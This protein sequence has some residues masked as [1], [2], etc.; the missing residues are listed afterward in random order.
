MLLNVRPGG[1]T[2][3]LPD[4]R[5]RDAELACQRRLR[6]A[7]GR[8]ASD[9]PDAVV[10]KFG[11]A[12]SCAARSLFRR[13]SC[14]KASKLLLSAPTGLSFCPGH[15]MRFGHFLTGLGPGRFPSLGRGHALSNHRRPLASSVWMVGAASRLTPARIRAEFPPRGNGLPA[16]VIPTPIWPCRSLRGH[17]RGVQCCVDLGMNLLARQFHQI[18]RPII[19][20]VDIQ[21]MDRLP[22][23]DRLIRMSSGPDD[24]G[25]RRVR[26]LEA[27]PRTHRIVDPDERPRYAVTGREPFTLESGMLWSGRILHRCTPDDTRSV[28]TRATR[29]M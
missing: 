18:L 20:R 24:S 3:D 28:I 16:S 27:K 6:R 15:L 9:L 17:P 8:P 12:V 11:G 25:S 5:L 21:V 7:F 29:S 22:G 4:Q 2:N 13:H 19:E 23:S 26:T 1:T 10:V 14:S